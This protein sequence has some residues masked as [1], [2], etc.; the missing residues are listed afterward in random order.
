MAMSGIAVSARFTSDATTE[1]SGAQCRFCAAPLRHTFVDL[2]MSPLCE[3]YLAAD[4]A[5]RDG[6]V[7]SAARLRVRAAASSCSSRSTSRRGDLHASTPTSRRTRTA[8]SSTRG[9]TST[10]MIDRFGL[11]ADSLV[12]ELASN[13]GY[14]LQ[15][16]VDA[17]H[18]GARASSRRPTSPQAAEEQGRR[19]RWS[20]LR[21]RAGRA[22]SSADGPARRPG[23]RQQRAGPGAGPERLRR[24]G[25]R[26][27]LA[28]D[29]RR[30]DRVPAPRCG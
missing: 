26:S 23:R 21:P 18:P 16:F 2:G 4:A 15:Y 1:A 29:G 25:S 27:L 7:L 14:L 30:H 6:A 3:S 17:R 8:G 19:R 10:T 12:V 22:S 9:A 13:D 5:R 28:P 11:G 24:P 20:V